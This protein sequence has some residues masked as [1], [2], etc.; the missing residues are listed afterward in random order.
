MVLQ[1]NGINFVH[2]NSPTMT[3]NQGRPSKV[4]ERLQGITV[5][6]SEC[7]KE[8]QKI[9]AT[10]IL[11]FCQPSIRLDA[12]VVILGHRINIHVDSTNE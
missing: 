1:L 2:S 11:F 9:R 7:M 6:Y 8:W 3:S 4:I 12:S 10:M 5:N